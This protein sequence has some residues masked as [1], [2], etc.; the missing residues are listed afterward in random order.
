MDLPVGT[1]GR[2]VG[3][4]EF[5][6]E[7]E[8]LGSHTTRR[9]GVMVAVVVGSDGGGVVVAPRATAVIVIVVD[10]LPLQC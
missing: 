4:C 3:A 1:M 6:E 9:S 2:F 10:T 8:V 5:C 7:C